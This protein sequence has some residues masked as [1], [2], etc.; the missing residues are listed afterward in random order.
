[1]QRVNS[2]HR[3]MC[4]ELLIRNLQIANYLRPMRKH[5]GMRPQDI[6]VLLKT[7]TIEKEEWQFKDLAVELSLS[8]AEVSESLNRSQL[9]G[10]ISDD[11]RKVAR[12]NVLEFIQYGLHYVFPQAPGAI[13]NGIPTAHSHPYFQKQFGAELK[14]VWPFASG[15]Q[16][17]AAIAPLYAGQP[18]AARQDER[19]YLLLACIDVVRVGKSRE[20]KAAMEVLKKELS[21]ELQ[22]K[23]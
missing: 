17:G 3:K 4:I 8:A 19:L 22:P 15:K 7:L 5:N 6:V 23:H 18:A 13:M 12:L 14:Y 16:R 1:M 9:A 10:L 21:H 11:K 20:V 2:G